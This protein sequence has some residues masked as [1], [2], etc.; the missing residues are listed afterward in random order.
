MKWLRR[1]LPAPIAPWVAATGAA[2]LVLAASVWFAVVFRHAG[3][4]LGTERAELAAARTA[5]DADQA[6]LI[7]VRSER[8]GTEATIDETEATTAQRIAERIWYDAL[9]QNAQAD[10]SSTEASLAETAL[11][12]AYVAAT[13]GETRACLDG[14]AFAVRASGAGDTNGAVAALRLA[15]S[16][17]ARTIALATGAEFPYDF[18]DPYV[19]RAGR[20]YYGYSTNSG[21]GDVQVIRSADLAT[22]EL[23]GDALPAYPAWARPGT[24]WAPAVLARDGHFVLYYAVRE[25]ETNRQC[26][27]RAIG[28]RP[29]GPFLDDSH[30]PMVCDAGGSIDPSPFVDV[31]GRAFLLWKSEGAIAIRSQ[32]LTGDGLAVT[33]T[34]TVLAGPDRAFERGVVEGPSLVTEGG[35]YFL[36][37]SANNWNSHA[38]AQAYATCAGPSGPCTKPGDGRVLV[39]GSQLTGPGGGEAFRDAD[40]R[41]WLAFHAFSGPDVGYP[42]SRYFH[43]ARMHVEGDRIRIDAPT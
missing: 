27:S 6:A 42:N 41:L 10:V 13:A 37:Y 33:G 4:Q 32:P 8:S 26:I 19:V 1:H 12:R 3:A 18:P 20:T 11:G 22:W 34:P 2:L 31:D 23:V 43:V 29:E 15:S 17:C 14:V 25:I 16:A 28:A 21:G 5:L 35:R 7:G 36:L 38:Y 24:T 9:I 39:S 40:G 30:G